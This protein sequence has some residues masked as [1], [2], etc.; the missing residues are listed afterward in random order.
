MQSNASRGAGPAAVAAGLALLLTSCA[1]PDL[2]DVP[3][4][5][6]AALV[7]LASPAPELD[8]AHSLVV[9]SCLADEGFQLPFDSTAG[10]ES[11]ASLVGI[12][13]LFASVETAQA[14][15]YV[16]T[17]SGELA[18]IDAFEQDLSGADRQSFAIA[19]R[20]SD[21]ISESVTLESGAV[22]SRNSDGC[23]AKA[24]VAV[25][26]S[27]QN[28]LL[29][30][31]FV[32]EINA[33]A[34]DSLGPIADAVTAQLGVYESCMQDAGFDVQ[35]LNAGTIALE[36]FGV[37]RAY[38]AEPSDDEQAMARTDYLCQ[39]KARLAETANTELLRYAGEW[40]VANESYILT[41]N[42]V[43]AQALERAND[44]IR[45]L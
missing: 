9:R 44:L 17:V 18:G 20:G 26:G 38:G 41:T 40:V 27:V 11:R 8:V 28:S 30:D 29:V 22:I 43:L 12:Q 6:R 31:S 3:P 35:G 37:Y 2:P 14:T 34:G 39:E 32:N 1:P 13:G 36:M 42:E 4:D 16:D 15:G 7:A 24:D 5:I 23:F 10:S 33:I 19:Y 25:Y 21:T 45:A